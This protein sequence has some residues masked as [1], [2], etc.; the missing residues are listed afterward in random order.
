MFP[1]KTNALQLNQ[2]ST[3]TSCARLCFRAAPQERSNIWLVG[4]GAGRRLFIA[5]RVKPQSQNLQRRALNLFHLL[6]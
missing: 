1:A 2:R 3:V 5:L 6:F 4:P